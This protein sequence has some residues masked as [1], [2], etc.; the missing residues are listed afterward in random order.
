MYTTPKT[1]EI[2]KVYNRREQ[3]PAAG[4]RKRFPI[5][6]ATEVWEM[7]KCF[8]AFFRTGKYFNAFM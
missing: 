2:Y 4:L 5:P 3:F 7:R 8:Q 1:Q 6:R